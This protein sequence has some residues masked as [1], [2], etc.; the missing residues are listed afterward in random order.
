M[1]DLRNDNNVVEIALAT[2]ADLRER[3]RK[4]LAANIKLKA[5]AESSESRVAEL[6]AALDHFLTAYCANSYPLS[7]DAMREAKQVLA[8]GNDHGTR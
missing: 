4:L 1:S 7:Q 8:K 2:E 3:N 6:E 5:R